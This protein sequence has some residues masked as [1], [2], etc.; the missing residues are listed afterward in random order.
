MGSNK[1]AFIKTSLS[2]NEFDARNVVLQAEADIG[3][4][5]EC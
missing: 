4:G 2:P 5:C 3:K 1:L